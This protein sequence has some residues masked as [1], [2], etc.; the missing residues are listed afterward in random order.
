MERLSYAFADGVA[1]A[2]RNVIKIKRVPEVLVGVL[3]TPLIFVLLCSAAPSTSPV[4]SIGSSL[5][6]APLH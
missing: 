5:S 2:R 4:A 1:I 3:I 6:E